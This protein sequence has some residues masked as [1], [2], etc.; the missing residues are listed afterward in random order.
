[1]RFIEEGRCQ[2]ASTRY[3]FVNSAAFCSTRH[4]IQQYLHYRRHG[5]PA[6]LES[7]QPSSGISVSG[8]ART[9]FGDYYLD[10][11]H[12]D[13]GRQRETDASSASADFLHWKSLLA[14]AVGI[15]VA[16]LGGRGASLMLNQPAI[17]TG[18]LTGTILGVA[19]FKGVPV[20]PLIAAGIL[21][22]MIGRM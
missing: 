1:M 14:V 8:K 22:L 12:H 2:N 16:Y 9:Y 19:L 21:S 17:T 7:A 15:L 18:L 10:D 13:A 6:S 5:C 3:A 4:S 20:G 11:R